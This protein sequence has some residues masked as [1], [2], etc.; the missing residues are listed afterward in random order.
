MFQKLQSFFTSWAS[1]V[2]P[3]FVEKKGAWLL[4]PVGRAAEGREAGSRP[5]NRP[6]GL[7]G[8][9]GHLAIWEEKRLAAGNVFHVVLS[10]SGEKGNTSFSAKH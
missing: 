5:R 2:S 4:Q 3:L 9:V 8:L 10:K 1:N 6:N 7:G